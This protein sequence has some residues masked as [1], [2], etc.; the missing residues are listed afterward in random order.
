MPAAM[1]RP[2][3]EHITAKPV[4]PSHRAEVD[5]PPAM[6]QLILDCL[7]KR[8]DARPQSVAVVAARLTDMVLDPWTPDRAKAWW[9]LHVPLGSSEEVLASGATPLEIVR[10]R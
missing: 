6:D 1:T 7:E 5:I 3:A 10:V 4:V 8:P 2:I 9:E